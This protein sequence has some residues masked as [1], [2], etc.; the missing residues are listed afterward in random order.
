V[1]NNE[2]K[3]KLL[4]TQMVAKPRPFLASGLSEYGL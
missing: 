2:K 4:A 1:V 3:A